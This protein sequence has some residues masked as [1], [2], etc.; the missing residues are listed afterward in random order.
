MT[1]TK[2]VILSF[3]SLASAAIAI[4]I[5]LAMFDLHS[6]LRSILENCLYYSIFCF[7]FGLTGWI[8][9]LPIVVFVS[10]PKGWKFWCVLATGVGIGPLVI[11]GIAIY[12]GVI[13]SNFNMHFAPEAWNIV[14]V[15]LTESSLTTV[16]YLALI[17]SKRLATSS[18]S[19]FTQEPL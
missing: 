9:A 15:A 8:L 5:G 6:P 10:D 19:G 14:L 13:T 18:W 16:I 4:G 1:R 12:G 17:R 7:V 3:V 11:F 2:R